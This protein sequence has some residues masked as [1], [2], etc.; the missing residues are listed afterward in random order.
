MAA[1]CWHFTINNPVATDDQCLVRLKEDIEN[2]KVARYCIVGFEEAPTTGTPHYQGYVQFMDKKSRTAVCAVL[3]GRASCLVAR[4]TAEDN[5]KYCSKDGLYEEVGMPQ[6]SGERTDLK[7][8]KELVK[9]GM[10]IGEIMDRTHTMQASLYAERYAKY[11]APQR[12]WKTWSAW[13]WGPSGCGK[14]NHK[15][16]SMYLSVKE[17]NAGVRY[18]IK[19]TSTGR[20]WDGYDGQE[21][22]VIDD[23]R[24]GGYDSGY[25]FMDVLGYCGE[26]EMRVQI[27]GGMVPFVAKW[28]VFTS[29]EPPWKVMK[30]PAE[31]IQQL[32]RRL[33]KVIQMEARV[34]EPVYK[35]ADDFV[36]PDC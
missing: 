16:K 8:V 33:E 17:K 30:D 29:V 13:I 12:T 18:F 32:K 14:T 20:W 9:K 6:W 11:H 22:V 26:E 19:K 3:G 10:G 1:K 36:A 28:V 27:K 15:A 24:K 25:S 7:E 23:I 34:E 21:F 4:G 2:G 5:Q 35:Y 31:D